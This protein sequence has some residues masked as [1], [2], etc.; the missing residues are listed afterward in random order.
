M[1]DK[2]FLPQAEN[3]LLTDDKRFQKFENSIIA[4]VLSSWYTWFSFVYFRQMEDFV[5]WTD[6]SAIKKH[7]LDYND[8]VSSLPFGVDCMAT[9]SYVAVYSF[10]HQ[11]LIKGWLHPVCQYELTMIKR[12]LERHKT[13]HSLVLWNWAV[14]LFRPTHCPVKRAV[15]TDYDQEILWK[16]LIRTE[17]CG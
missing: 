14:F 1:A 13:F 15:W 11:T 10:F 8:M 5:T 2:Y 4:H 17:L 6:T 9:V 12:F 3:L 7:V 16:V